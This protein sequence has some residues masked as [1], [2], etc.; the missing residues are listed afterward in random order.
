MLFPGNS[1]SAVPTILP[2]LAAQ[3]A[4]KFLSVLSVFSLK[5]AAW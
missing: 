2:S 5:S 3:V 1:V 4:N